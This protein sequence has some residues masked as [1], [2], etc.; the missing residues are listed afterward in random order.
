MIF[1]DKR[2]FRK[3]FKYCTEVRI[4]IQ[5][6]SCLCLAFYILFHT[7]VCTVHVTTYLW[8]CVCILIVYTY[9]PK[10]SCWKYSLTKEHIHM[11]VF[12]VHL[13]NTEKA[14]SE[15]GDPSR[16]GGDQLTCMRHTEL[17][18]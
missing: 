10:F 1:P 7:T 3:D 4:L 6:Y 8:I 16:G 15:G 14:C 18:T 11:Y 12:L 2:E 9:G 13:K 5:E 17:V